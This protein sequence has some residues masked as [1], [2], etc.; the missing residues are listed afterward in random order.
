M[1][2]VFI[3]YRSA[4]NPFGAAGIH[5][6]LTLG[7]RP[8]RVFRDCVSLDAG[9]HYPTAIM[10]ELE[11]ADLVVAVIGPQ[12]L[13]AVDPTTKQRLIDRPG[14]WVRRE[15]VTAFRRNIPVVP[16][17]LKDTPDDAQLPL[18]ADLPADIRRLATLQFIYV[19]QR[20]LAP[21]LEA[22]V[23]HVRR[24]LTASGAIPPPETREVPREVFYSLV[25]ALEAIPCLSSD[26]DRA[27]LINQLP[28]AIASSVRYSPHRRI[29][30][31]NIVRTCLDHEGGLAEML[32]MLRH[33]EGDES[34][35]LHRLTAVARDLP[36]ELR[37]DER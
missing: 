3:N 6:S 17:L 35:P 5:E 21:D 31:M 16:V 1:A 34:I 24:L 26:T 7:L 11:N 27:T 25:D 19:S 9:A 37:P 14:D 32:A 13:A 30:A 22:L 10:T 29:H 23:N 33:I 28:P 4:D 18:P 12:W 8:H 20:R 36:P 15:L 2:H